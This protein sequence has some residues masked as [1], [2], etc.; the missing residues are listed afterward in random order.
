M[1]SAPGHTRAVLFFLSL[2]ALPCISAAQSLGQTFYSFSPGHVPAPPASCFEDSEIADVAS[3][4]A[5]PAANFLGRSCDTPAIPAS[6]PDPCNALTLAGS[7]C[8]FR[9][10]PVRMDLKAIG[11]EGR[12]IS[13]ARDKVLEIL[14]GDN[15]CAAWYR[16]KD[17]N[18]AV[19]FRTLSFAI[20]HK[21]EGVV[22]ESRDLGPLSIFQDPYVA[23]V[24]QADGRYAAVT[25]NVRGAFFS[26]V[27]QAIGVSREGGPPAMRPP[28]LLHVGAYVGG[29]LPAQ[30]VTML[31]EFGHV[32]DLLPNDEHGQDG[33][34]VHNTD[35]VLQHCR[36][37]IE[38]RS[39]RNVLA[40][41]R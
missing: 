20:D 37:E 4:R 15:A 34:S 18:P 40:A 24:F 17:S 26:P 9:E 33:K 38:S 32:V 23:R 10:D 6:V 29:T 14:E 3:R 16:E 25:I 1:C 7:G 21:G 28:R 13:R 12:K 22:R 35:A 11:R 27:A 36:N 19:T 41:T 39:T 30:V 8:G 2:S 31:H 5:M